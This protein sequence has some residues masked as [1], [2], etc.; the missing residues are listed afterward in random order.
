MS[1]LADDRTALAADRILDAA[2]VL[3]AE[4]GA[5]GVGMDQVAK[6]AGC[7]RATLYRYFDNRQALMTAFAHREARQIVELVAEEV[8]TVKDPAERGVTA[9]VGTLAAVRQRPLLHHW[10]AGGDS[11][12]LTE[13]LRESP[14]IESFAAGF[15]SAGQEHAGPDLG[16]WV[17]RMIL[18]LPRRTRCRR[19]GRRRLVTRFLAP[20]LSC[21]SPAPVKRRTRGWRSLP[22]RRRSRRR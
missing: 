12:L 9:I 7:S 18:S 22:R 11:A 21:L 19:R 4:Q 13:I 14:L 10:Y 15:V 5:T 3:F 6:A 2:A 16:R 8:A 20:Y 1:W 17:I